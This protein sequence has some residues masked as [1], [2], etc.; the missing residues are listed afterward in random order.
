MKKKIKVLNVISS[1]NPIHGGTSSATIDLSL[2]L[3]KKNFKI[4]IVTNDPVEISYLRSKSV[5][6][7]NLGRGIG[8]YNFSIKL[9][10]WL[11]KNIRNYDQYI[12]NGIWQFNTLVAKILLEK[13]FYVFTHG[14]LDPYFGTEFLKKIKKIIYWNLVEKNNMKKSKAILLT[15]ENERKFQNKTFVNTNSLN[16]KIAKIGII[17]PNINKKKLDS[18]FLKNFPQLKNKKYLIF[19]GRFHKKKG[20]EILLKAF[21]RIIKKN[22]KI[23]LL[24]VGPNNIYKN[25]LEKLSKNLG[26]KNQIVWSDILL[27][28]AKWSVIKNADGM[29][30]SS[31]GE[32]FGISIVESL[33]MGVPVITTTKVNIHNII[34]KY[35]AGYIAKNNLNSF[36]NCLLGYINLRNLYKTKMKLNSLKCFNNEFNL[37]YNLSSISNLL[38]K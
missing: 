28:E 6:V 25:H 12:F 27:N 10:F 4:D 24:M 7:I 8:N 34:Q 26:L 17:K 35:N 3:S 38:K 15:N 19:L 20:C 2:A 29:V 22:K 18:I 32:N 9:F 30:L 21:S 1:L 16:K 23:Y 37:N 14:Q 5:K 36:Y 33:S 11:K 31:H 13:K